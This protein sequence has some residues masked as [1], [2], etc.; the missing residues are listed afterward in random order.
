MTY[1]N[2]DLTKISG[3]FNYTN[4]IKDFFINE[5]WKQWRDINKQFLPVVVKM[6][7]SWLK[8]TDIKEKL[9]YLG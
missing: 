2:T 3:D 4:Q 8:E 6:K 7:E 1:T 9:G 5:V